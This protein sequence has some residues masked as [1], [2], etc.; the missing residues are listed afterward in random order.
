MSYAPGHVPAEYS[1]SFLARELRR[2]QE[3]LNFEEAIGN[4]VLNQDD[5]P[6]AD[7]I[8]TTPTVLPIWTRRG[9]PIALS[10]GPIK[11]DPRVAPASE[12]QVLTS[13]IYQVGF[14]ITFEHA[15]AVE[16]F[17]EFFL[18]GVRSFFLDVLDESNQQNL[19]S[20]ASTVQVVLQ[21]DDVV[22]LRAYTLS[23]TADVSYISAEI[24]VH[25]LRDLR[26]RFS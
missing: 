2:I 26:T 7:T 13:G 12:I 18:N 25:K 22:D 16:V 24:Y 10:D 3:V 17:Y 20:V 4:L 9:P 5:T 21:K 8:T 23:G 15:F 1:A 19:A 11:T 14:F 6:F